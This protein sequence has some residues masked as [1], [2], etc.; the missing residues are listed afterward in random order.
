[1]LIWDSC[2]EFGDI[3]NV[4]SDAYQRC[5]CVF[6]WSDEWKSNNNK[7]EREKKKMPTTSIAMIN[8]WKSVLWATWKG[9]KIHRYTHNMTLLQEKI[10]S[11]TA[12]TITK[13]N[14]S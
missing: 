5:I 8:K 13:A 12:T 14:V 1:M 9:D 11:V 4:Q 6:G 10:E 2:F 3:W 7:E